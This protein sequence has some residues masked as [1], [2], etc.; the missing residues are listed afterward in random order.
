MATLSDYDKIRL[1]DALLNLEGYMPR[2]L[3]SSMSRADKLEMFDVMYN[4]VARD[5]R[6]SVSE[7]DYDLDRLPPAKLRRMVELRRSYGHLP[8]DKLPEHIGREL[9]GIMQLARKP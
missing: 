2:D 8:A 1:I 7:P 9:F 6:Q 4:A 5:T 3:A